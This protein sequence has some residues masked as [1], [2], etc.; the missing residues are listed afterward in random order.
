MIAENGMGFPFRELSRLTLHDDC[1]VA[2]LEVVLSDRKLAKEPRDFNFIGPTA[3]TE[4]LTLGGID[5]VTLANNHTLDYGRAGYADTQ[6]A[7]EAAGVGWFGT[8]SAAVW[9]GEDGLMIGFL[10]ASY[11]L[12]GSRYKAFAAQAEQLRELGCSAVI[13]VMHAG[14]EYSRRPPDA[15]QKQIVSRAVQCGS[16][17]IV[18]HHPHVVQGL[19]VVDGVPV[20]YSLGNCSFGGNVNPKDKD[21]LVLQAVLSFREGALRGITLR[22]CPI[23]VTSAEE[24]NNYSP[25]FLTGEDAER[26]LEAM[27]KSTGTDPGAWDA[28]EGAAVRFFPAGGGAEESP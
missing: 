9:R 10:G 12:T 23:S 28:E 13:T 6:A 7:L 24:G 20:V 19:D 2:N 21:A 25:R 17:L 11:S 3:N 15:Y 18:G 22:F 8:D 26:V 1:T 16:C 5:C 27:R 4:I 14:T